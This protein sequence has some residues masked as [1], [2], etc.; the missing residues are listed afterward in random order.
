MANRNVAPFDVPD[1]NDDLR[2]ITRAV[3]EAAEMTRA[4]NQ[5]R[6]IDKAINLGREMHRQIQEA[7][8]VCRPIVESIAA[9]VPESVASARRD[10]TRTFDSTQEALFRIAKQQHDMAAAARKQF[11]LLKASGLF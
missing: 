7:M 4:I 11:D 10:V 1:P 6:E 8:E 3:N 2:E 5:H 9:Q